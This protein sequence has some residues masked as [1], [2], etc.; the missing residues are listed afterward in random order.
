MT[1]LVLPDLHTPYHHPDA[2]RFLS[3]MKRLYEPDDIICIGDEIDAHTLSRFDSDPN[4]PGA[5][6]ELQAA[7]DA[8]RRLYQIF[9]A[10]RCCISNHTFRAYKQAHRV[11]IP[12]AYM[13]DIREVLGAP[14]GWK[15]RDSWKRKGVTYV[16]GDGF[17]GQTPQLAAAERLRCNVALG[18]IHHAAGALWSYAPS[19]A[20]WGLSVG[21]LI[22][23][24]AGAFAYAR[25]QARRPALGC[26][27]IQDGVPRFVPL[28]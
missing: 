24:T 21:C 20:V 23:D 19:G 4:L 6:C 18:H 13:R 10:A 28:S 27:I 1:T 17:G 5:A 3:D 14:A 22:D 15:W 12:R 25:Y 11:G 16:H 8:L 26:G 2:F 7:R 9:P